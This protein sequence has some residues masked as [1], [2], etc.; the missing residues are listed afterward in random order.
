[1]LQRIFYF[2]IFAI[3]DGHAGNFA[4]D[5]AS[6]IIIPGIAEKITEVLIFIQQKIQAAKKDKNKPVVEI[7]ENIPQEEE[8]EENPL[9]KYI[10]KDNKINYEVLLSDEIIKAD[11]ILLDRMASAALFCGSTLCLVLVDITNKIIVCANVGDS[12]A[13]MRDVHGKT[14]ALSNDHKPNNLE[15]MKRI[16][17]NGGYISNKDGCW[18]VDGTLATS[19]ALGDYP[20]KMKKVIIADPEITTFRFKDFR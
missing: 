6:D 20:L 4:S 18:R 12:R 5:Y 10:T 11:K 8:E 14:I 1:M 16:R 13:I 2:R 17:E 15:E 9:E 7:T 3:C 19:R